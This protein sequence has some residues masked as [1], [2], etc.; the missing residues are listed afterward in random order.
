MRED[1]TDQFVQPILGE[2]ELSRKP[3]TGKPTQKIVGGFGSGSGYAMT[4]VDV[5][6]SK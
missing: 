5:I 3:I 2:G 6:R 1:Q 4:A